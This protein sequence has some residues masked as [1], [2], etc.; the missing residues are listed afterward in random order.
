MSKTKK[1]KRAS[2]RTEPPCSQALAEIIMGYKRT[3]PVGWR[4]ECMVTPWIER[5]GNCTCTWH[6]GLGEPVSVCGA[7]L[8]PTPLD[9]DGTCFL[10]RANDP[11][12][13]RPEAQRR[14][15]K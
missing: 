4:Y 15:V 3:P 2:R 5:D 14:D 10:F 1:P 7:M 13:F 8:I 11:G 12:H 9:V 6:N